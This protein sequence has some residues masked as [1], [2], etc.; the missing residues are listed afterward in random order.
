MSRD[1]RQ[2]ETFVVAD[3]LVIDTYK[4]TGALPEYERYGL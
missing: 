3:A 1:H 4:I 2:F